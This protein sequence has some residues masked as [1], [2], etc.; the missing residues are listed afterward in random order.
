MEKFLIKAC[1]KIA[2]KEYEVKFRIELDTFE[3]VCFF[4]DRVSVLREA[5]DLVTVER[6]TI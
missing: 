3:D 1:E 6:S 4:L 2:N 5:Y